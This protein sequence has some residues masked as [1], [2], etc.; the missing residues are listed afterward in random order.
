MEYQQ[1]F[2]KKD[3]QSYLDEFFSSWSL[4]EREL[5]AC[6]TSNNGMITFFKNPFGSLYVGAD[7]L[8]EPSSINPSSI[9]FNSR[10][11]W[12]MANHINKV[13][14]K[15]QK[16]VPSRASQTISITNMGT[17]TK[18]SS[19][20]VRTKYFYHASFTRSFIKCSSWA[21]HKIRV[22]HSLNENFNWNLVAFYTTPSI[23]GEFLVH[24]RR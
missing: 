8:A 13:N 16:H 24:A 9:L 7:S 4:W 14:R 10:T 17:K 2:L 21:T 19:L 11:I 20:Q 18:S 1:D 6:T 23:F 22:I 3:L 15:C 12:M 5:T